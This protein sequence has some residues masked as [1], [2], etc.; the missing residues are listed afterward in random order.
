VLDPRERAW[1]RIL[2]A[3]NSG[4]VLT[5]PVT[6]AVKG[7][8]VVDLGVRGFVPSS[9]IGLNVPRN[10]NQFV[11][12]NLR[13]RVLEVDRRRQTVI[14][15]NRQILEEERASKRKS[16]LG[17]LEEGQDRE[18]VVRRLT[19]IGAFVDVGGV[20][21][22]LHVS[23][24]SWKRIDH[25]KDVLKV[26]QKVQVKVLRVDAE[27]GRVSLSMRRLMLDPWEEARRKYAIGASVQ[28]KI[29]SLIPQGALVEV[30]EG[31]E[32]FIPI[33][34]LAG[35]RIAAPE[36]VVQPGQEVEAVVID[37]RPR[38]RRIVFS[39]RKLE[40]K[41]ERAVVDN[42]Q[43]KTRSTGERT[44]L[45]DLFGHLFEEYGHPDDAAPA[46]ADG[47]D[48]SVMAGE[49]LPGA[50]MDEPTP[51][52]DAPAS[53]GGDA[54]E[55]TASVVDESGTSL[56]AVGTEVSAVDLEPGETPEA[57]TEPAS[58]DAAAP[59]AAGAVD[60]T[61][62]AEVVEED[63]APPHGDPLREAALDDDTG[64]ETSPSTGSTG[65]SDEP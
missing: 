62:A 26:G 4:E 16:A 28:V 39:L 64:G 40:Q 47:G 54:D 42:Y 33:S 36:E 51:G 41:R 52:P 59:D 31:L 53:G 27:A 61:P 11:G 1:D 9:Q 56:A 14:L 21:G 22:L 12:Q 49:P 6:E 23:E 32:G 30:D 43:K 29:A 35:R 3:K 44:T 8:V 18:G 10:L 7:G 63:P 20:D 13:L 2:R 46:A 19:D 55:A 17:R 5:A 38:E 57:A 60:E 24:I 58:E 45:G 37:L 65:A 50:L 48:A 25:P 34:E 15:T